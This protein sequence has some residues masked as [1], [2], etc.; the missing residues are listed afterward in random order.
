MTGARDKARNN[1]DC[2]KRGR[3]SSDPRRWGAARHGNLL[4]RD[5]WTLP[6][7]PERGGSSK[8]CQGAAS[9]RF[10][11]DSS[12]GRPSGSTWMAPPTDRLVLYRD[13]TSSPGSVQSSDSNELPASQPAHFREKIVQMRK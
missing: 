6:F 2:G 3:D 10:R 4:G 5:G 13:A 12:G 7:R 11:M 9:R 1:K 8:N